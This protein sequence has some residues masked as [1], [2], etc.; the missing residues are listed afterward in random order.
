[1]LGVVQHLPASPDVTV[2]CAWECM[3][4]KIPERYYTQGSRVGLYKTVLVKFILYFPVVIVLVLSQFCVYGVLVGW[5]S[6]SV[7]CSV[8]LTIILSFQGIAEASKRGKGKGEIE[9][10]RERE[11][12]RKD[13]E[14]G[15][16]ERDKERS[17]EREKLRK[18]CKEN[19][20]M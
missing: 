16:G 10:E 2:S 9:R 7:I 5:L 12:E 11:R 19:M 18:N 15:E 17:R 14:R 13:R 1:M 6:R 3:V 20:K 8:T 4:R